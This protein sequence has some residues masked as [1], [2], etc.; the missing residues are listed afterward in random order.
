MTNA[1]PS[2][3][4]LQL[5]LMRRG[6]YRPA[7]ISSQAGTSPAGSSWLK[8]AAVACSAPRA[9]SPGRSD[10]ITLP[11]LRMTDRLLVLAAASRR[12]V[13]GDWF[14]LNFPVLGGGHARAVGLRPHEATGRRPVRHE[15]HSAGHLPL[16][17]DERT[18]AP[19]LRPDPDGPA[20]RD[21][22]GLQV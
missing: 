5:P 11:P 7:S 6:M 12:G 3:R 14:D 8:C 2:A 21:A 13:R 16:L 17:A 15:D 4:P 18:L 9:R 1:Q 22:E 10:P 20:R 19:V